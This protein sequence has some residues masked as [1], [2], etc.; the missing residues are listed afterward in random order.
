[1]ADK[2]ITHFVY[3][4]IPI[5][6][7]DWVAY[8]DN[9]EPD[10][11]GW[12]LCGHGATEAGAILDLFDSDDRVVPCEACGTEG[13]IITWSGSIDRYGNPMEDAHSCPHCDGTGGEII[14]TQPIEMEDLS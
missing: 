4:P 13:Q 10:D 6:S 3:P 1:M 14:K 8:Y 2:I 5:R 9:H 12:M 11:E 7:M